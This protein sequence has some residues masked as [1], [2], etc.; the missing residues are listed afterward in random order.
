MLRI[1]RKFIQTGLLKQ[2]IAHE[3][4]PPDNRAFALPMKLFDLLPSSKEM[5]AYSS[6]RLTRKC[7]PEQY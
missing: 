2:H 4:I 3:S 5:T 1:L 7:T 6:I